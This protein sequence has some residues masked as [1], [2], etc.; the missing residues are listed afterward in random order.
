MG[1]IVEIGSADVVCRDPHHPCTAAFLGDT[2][3]R[4]APRVADL[5]QIEG[6]NVVLAKPKSC[7]FDP[8]CP[9]RFDPAIRSGQR[10]SKLHAIT[11]PLVI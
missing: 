4:S 1:Q 2:D 6:D 8:R 10:S 7:A 9:R 3:R 5:G 11:A